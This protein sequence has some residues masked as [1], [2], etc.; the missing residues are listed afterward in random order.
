MH[1]H[2][3]AAVGVLVTSL[4]L[5]GTGAASASG[6]D[7][8]SGPDIRKCQAAQAE[9]DEQD[10][11]ADAAEAKAATSEKAATDAKEALSEYDD[12]HGGS[13]EDPVDPVKRGQ[14]V[15]DATRA[16]STATADRAEATKQRSEADQAARDETAACTVPPGKDGK[17]GKVIVDERVILLDRGVCARAKVT[18]DPAKLV[19][20]IVLVP[21][22][23]RTPAPPAAKPAPGDTVIV[24]ERKDRQA[25][26][27]QT[28]EG[29]LAVTH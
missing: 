29:D 18:D 8:P 6:S 24:I 3:G 13:G 20:V 23:D 17:D 15:T 21:C 19:K 9:T 28:V 2:R 10:R 12:T 4:A 25:P 16:Q 14:L 22:P 5:L 1:Q 27:P 11:Q 26:K 7:Q